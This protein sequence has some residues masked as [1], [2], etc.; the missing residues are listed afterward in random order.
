[1]VVA[2][3]VGDSLLDDGIVVGE[4]AE[5]AADG[6][7]GASPAAAQQWQYFMAQEIAA[8][9]GGEI[10]GVGDVFQPVEVEIL[11]YLFSGEVDERPQDIAV[12]GG[13]GFESAAAGTAH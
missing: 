7:V 6:F 12:A 11:Q 1:M 8:V 3:C 10:R 13:H 4:A 5:S 2:K 9:V